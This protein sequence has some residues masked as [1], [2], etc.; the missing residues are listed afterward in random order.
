MAYFWL[1]QRK[2][3]EST[4]SDET[5]EVYHYRDS[6]TGSGNLSEGDWFVYYMPREYVLFG[7]GRI[8]EITQE[9]D[10]RMTSYYAHVEDYRPFDPHLSAR[11]VKSEISFLKGR[12]GLQ[13]VPQM[14][15]YEIDEEDYRTILRAAGEEDLLSS[16]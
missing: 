1:N 9:D 10:L 11:D 3:E 8:Q 2:E 12:N 16:E 14:S 5:G 4:Y 6:V 7:A 13:G 15:I